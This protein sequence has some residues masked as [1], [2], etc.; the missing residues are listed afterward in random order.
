MLAGSSLRIGI[1]RF[2]TAAEIDFAVD[3]AGGGCGLNRLRYRP[4]R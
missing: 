2:T 4:G 3:A 1:G